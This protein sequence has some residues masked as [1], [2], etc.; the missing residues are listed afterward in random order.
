MILAT[1][2]R[3]ASPDRR[4]RFDGMKS[5]DQNVIRTVVIAIFAVLVVSLPVHAQEDASRK[6]YDRASTALLPGF[7]I[8]RCAA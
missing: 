1:R 2:I 3:R 4:R 7:R 5:G 6:A 8:D